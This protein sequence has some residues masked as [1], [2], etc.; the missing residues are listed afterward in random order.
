MKKRLDELFAYKRL[1]FADIGLV[2]I[3]GD[4]AAARKMKLMDL[5]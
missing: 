4:A 5:L 3:K 1:H 2:L